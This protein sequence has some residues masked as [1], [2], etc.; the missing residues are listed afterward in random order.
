MYHTVSSYI[1]LTM[2]H[3]VF[4]GRASGGDSC[5][6]DSDNSSDSDSYD[7]T[8]NQRIGIYGG[9][10][11]AAIILVFSKTILNYLF[12]I[13]ASRNLHNKMFRSILRAPVLFFDTNPVGMWCMWCIDLF[14]IL[15][16]TELIPEKTVYKEK[17]QRNN[18][19]R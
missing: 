11:F 4:Y 3:V 15:L 5:G 6:V 8:T 18:I 12:C 13:S 2:E 10:V 7:L 19:F 17:V 16:H 1:Q 14:F 9:I